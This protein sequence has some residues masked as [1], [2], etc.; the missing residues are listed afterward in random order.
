MIDPVVWIESLCSTQDETDEVF[1]GFLG[2]TV[3]EVRPGV[4]GL[5]FSFSRHV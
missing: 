2:G 3:A 4:E 5:G 1:L